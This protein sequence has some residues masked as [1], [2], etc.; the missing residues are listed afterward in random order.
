VHGHPLEVLS[1]SEEVVDPDRSQS[2]EPV[3]RRHDA[4]LDLEAQEVL[5]E[6]VDQLLVDGVGDNRVALLVDLGE[7]RGD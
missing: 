4:Q 1:A 3:V 6:R 7:M 5:I 2:F